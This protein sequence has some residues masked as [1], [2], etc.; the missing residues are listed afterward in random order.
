M[1]AL[2]LTVQLC[3]RVSALHRLL[4]AIDAMCWDCP[5]MTH[6]CLEVAAVGAGITGGDGGGAVIDGVWIHPRVETLGIRPD[7]E[8]VLA[9]KLSDISPSEKRWS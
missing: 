9:G 3:L 1:R 5:A 8:A 7:V 4:L 6:L 2:T